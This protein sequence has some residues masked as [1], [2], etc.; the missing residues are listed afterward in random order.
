VGVKP[1]RIV[2][3]GA[4]GTLAMTRHERGLAPSRSASDLIDAIGAHVAGIELVAVDAFSRPSANLGFADV[5]HLARLVEQAASDGASGVVVTQGTDTI[6][7]TAFA[8][9]LICRADIPIVVTGGMRGAAEPGADGPANLIGAI[10]AAGAAPA[11]I[12]VLVVMNDEVHAARYVA[13]MHTTALDAFCSG[14]AGA[15][16]RIE[17]GALRLGSAS[18]PKLEAGLDDGSGR[19]PRVALLRLGI[20]DDGYLIGAVAAGEFAGCVIEAMGAGHVPASLVGPLE[21]LATGMPVVLASRTGSGRVC[22]KTYAYPGSEI[23]L[24]ARNLIWAGGLSGLKARV[25]LT[26][27]VASSPGNPAGKFEEIASLI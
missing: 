23:D 14:D 11:G 5:V 18:L 24:L 26:L 7:E 21:R 12:G 10:I 3:I 8:L 27:C 20:D 6:E 16:G 1:G 22:R 9:E 4:G 15:I 19:W 13:K 25:L 17:E 2:V